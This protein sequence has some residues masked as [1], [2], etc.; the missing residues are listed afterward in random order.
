MTPTLTSASE[1]VWL[2]SATRIALPSRL[3]TACSHTV[4]PRLTASVPIMTT[5][6]IA[7]TVGAGALPTIPASASLPIRYAANS[8]IAPMMADAYV[9]NLLCPYGWSRSAGR[10]A[11][12]MPTRPMTLLAPSNIE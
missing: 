4:T 8:N 6:D 2:A 10:L 9:S 5:N 12:A 3:P 7:S 11:S 1:A